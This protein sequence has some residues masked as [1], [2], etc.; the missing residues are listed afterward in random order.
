MTSATGAVVSAAVVA[1]GVEVAV[2]VAPTAT[3][4]TADRAAT[5]SLAM[6]MPDQRMVGPRMVAVRKATLAK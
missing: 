1:K 2:L 4:A 5:A 6:P 3:A